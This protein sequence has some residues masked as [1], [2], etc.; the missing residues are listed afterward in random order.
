MKKEMIKNYK[1]FNE[2]LR[3]KLVGPSEDEVMD[4]FKDLS[5]NDLL[6]KSCKIGFLRGVEIALERGANVHFNGEQSLAETVYN[7]NLDIFKLLHKNGADIHFGRDVSLR[8]ASH[9]GNTEM[10]KYL[11]DNGADV[12]V[13]NNRPLKLATEQGHTDIVE[14]LK[15]YM[16]R[17]D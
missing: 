1:Q 17:N 15:K 10:V 13:M 16:E 14:L 5:P 9:K 7:N 11:L 3:D 12:H 8:D 2:S 4:N 6:V